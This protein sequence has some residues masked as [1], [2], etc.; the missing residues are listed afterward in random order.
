[1]LRRVVLVRTDVSKERST[2][3]NRMTRIC[4]VGTTLA[5]NSNRHTLRRNTATR[6]NI[7]KDGILH[8]RR[9]ENLKSYINIDCLSFCSRAMYV[10]SYFQNEG[11]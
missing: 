5:L 7:L 3:I 6:P 9:R 8:G 10:H 11:K 1:M 2:Y 4:E